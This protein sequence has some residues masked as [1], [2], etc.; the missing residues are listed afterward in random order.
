M[1]VTHVDPLIICITNKQ[2]IREGLSKALAKEP[3]PIVF[4]ESPAEALKLEQENLTSVI[5]DPLFY[6]ACPSCGELDDWPNISRRCK[7][8]FKPKKGKILYTDIDSPHHLTVVILA[9]NAPKHV[10]NSL[11]EKGYWCLRMKKEQSFLVEIPKVIK[12]SLKTMS[13]YYRM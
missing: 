10:V 9:Y 8:G 7:C 4:V 11:R 13:R 6:T 1:S 3:W 2:M 12:H 5:I